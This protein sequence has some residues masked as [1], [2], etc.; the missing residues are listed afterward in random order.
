MCT[1][2]MG[3]LSTALNIVWFMV[4]HAREHFCIVSV[5]STESGPWQ[6]AGES[7][8]MLVWICW[9]NNK[10][11]TTVCLEYSGSSDKTV[12]IQEPAPHYFS[13]VKS[14]NCMVFGDFAVLSHLKHKLISEI[15][16]IKSYCNITLT[17]SIFV[18]CF[19]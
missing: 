5:M 4:T 16:G 1:K 17:L 8:V 19:P 6:R 18:I 9:L 11:K 3:L 10:R 14:C 2:F 15:Q 7:K 12:H 13:Q